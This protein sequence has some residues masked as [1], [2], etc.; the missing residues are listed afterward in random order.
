MANTTKISNYRTGSPRFG[1]RDYKDEWDNSVKISYLTPEELEEYRNGKRGGTKLYTY[2]DYKKLKDA[3]KSNAEIAK[4]MKI[5]EPTLY[6][7]LKVWKG[8]PLQ[9]KKESH[10]KAIHPDSDVKTVL[11]SKHTQNDKTTENEAKI[12]LLKKENERLQKDLAFWKEHAEKLAA[13]D[14]E[15][16]PKNTDG[17]D[18]HELFNNA[19]AEKENLHK[20]ILILENQIK[21]LQNNSQVVASETNK[22]VID[23]ECEKKEIQ[24]KYNELLEDYYSLKEEAAPLRQLVLINLRNKVGALT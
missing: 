3:G 11:K 7:R 2:D 5:S 13:H 21:T 4:E 14:P 1:T 19:M 24:K 10:E 23:I 20:E 22:I 18:Y 9:P 6:N 12:T 8:E 15:I 17:P 16:E